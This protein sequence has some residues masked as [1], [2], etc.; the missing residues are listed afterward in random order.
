[1][2]KDRPNNFSAFSRK[3][4]ILMN[5]IIIVLVG[6]I[7]VIIAYLGL[8]LF[9]KHGQKHQVPNVIGMSYTEAIKKLH[10]EGFKIEIRDSVYLDNVKPGYVVE[11]YPDA[12][13]IVKPGRRIFLYINAVNPK[14]VVMDPASDAPGSPALAGNGLRAALAILEEGGFK[15]IR[16]VYIPGNTDRVARVLANG[17]EVKVMQKVPINAQITV[18]VYNNGASAVPDPDMDQRYID[19]KEWEKEIDSYLESDP[20]DNYGETVAPEEEEP[21][22]IPAEIPDDLLEY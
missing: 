7:G 11:Q 21:V 12:L 19:Q 5:A 20:E 10:D 2:S 4:P 1:M 17:R 22:P 9:T 3:H 13:S 18:E 16:V 6:I 8:T 15:N 14:Q